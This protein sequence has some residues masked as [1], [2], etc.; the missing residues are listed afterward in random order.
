M[1]EL[2][3]QLILRRAI[4]TCSVLYYPAQHSPNPSKRG[5]NREQVNGINIS[6]ISKYYCVFYDSSNVTLYTTQH[7][8]TLC[9]ISLS[10]ISVKCD[11]FN[12]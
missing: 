5:G 9:F 8:S 3:G 1:I 12:T 10:L 6:S 4:E 7:P 11:T 2:S